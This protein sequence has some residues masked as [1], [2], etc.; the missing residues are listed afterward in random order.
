MTK[1]LISFAAMTV[2]V[3]S[4]SF[5]VVERFRS[6]AV[7]SAPSKAPLLRDS[8]RLCEMELPPLEE[9]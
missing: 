9:R 5:L 2:L 8:A 4:V 6:Q 3:G 7:L 1:K